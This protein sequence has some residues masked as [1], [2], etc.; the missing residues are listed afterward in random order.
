MKFTNCSVG[1]VFAIILFLAGFGFGTVAAS[2]QEPDVRSLLKLGDDDGKVSLLMYRNEY[3][4][5][6]D[7]R[8]LYDCLQAKKTMER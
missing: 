7:I 8:D 5:D 4:N 6:G 1:I 3:M 2:G